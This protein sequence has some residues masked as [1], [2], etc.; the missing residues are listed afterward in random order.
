MS[1][2][3][4]IAASR[5]TAVERLTPIKLKIA[6]VVG[7]VGSGSDLAALLKNAGTKA[8]ECHVLQLAQSLPSCVKSCL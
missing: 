4:R 2:K 3:A 8:I 5:C 6:F 7:P 1:P